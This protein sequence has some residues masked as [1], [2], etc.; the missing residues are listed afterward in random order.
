[1]DWRRWY[2]F[3]AVFDSL[4]KLR[5]YFVPFDLW[6]YVA[7]V[8]V[9]AVV[10]SRAGYGAVGDVATFAVGVEA[11]LRLTRPAV[12]LAVDN[13]DLFAAAVALLAVL[14][15][16][17]AVFEF[18]FVDILWEDDL[19]LRKLFS[20]R[21]REGFSLFVFRVAATAAFFLSSYVAVGLL[22]NSTE[23]TAGLIPLAAA[24]ALLALG[25]SV[26]NGLV[27]DF[28]VPIMIADGRR[29]DDAVVEVVKLFRR[30]PRQLSLYVGVRLL[31]NAAILVG[32]TVVSVVV[33]ATIGLPLAGLGYAVELTSGGLD[34]A[35]ATAAGVAVAV[36]LVVIYLVLLLVF[37]AVFVQ[38]PVRFYLRCYPLY[39][40][41]YTDERYRL[42]EERPADISLLDFLLGRK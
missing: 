22:R 29:L 27:T 21:L 39:V 35:L 34:A 8:V 32:A 25:F 20:Q 31:L 16:V 41:G 13:V 11:D 18:V 15:F 38:L 1:M 42:L 17:S 36:V 24:V 23:S 40:L 33:A 5:Y 4:Y 14:V 6:R 2:A 19:S 7:L 10:G 9:T 30:E 26:V 12:E 28:A 3:D 37:L